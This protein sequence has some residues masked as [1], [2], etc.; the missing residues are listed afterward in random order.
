M[1]CARSIGAVAITCSGYATSA[2]RERRPWPYW[3]RESRTSSASERVAKKNSR[4]SG[5]GPRLKKGGGLCSTPRYPLVVGED[6]TEVLHLLERFARAAHDAGQG[7]VGHD[8]RQAGFFHQQPVEVAQQR[9]A[10]GQHHALFGD[11]GAELGRGLLEGGLDR[12]HDLVERFGERLEDLVGRDGEAP[13]NALGQVAAL[14]FHL[15]H[16]GA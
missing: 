14:H 1:P 12:R 13:R 5:A 10:A 15:A 4:T 7:I 8:Y 9:A 11:V 6:R 3:K 16:F 2:S